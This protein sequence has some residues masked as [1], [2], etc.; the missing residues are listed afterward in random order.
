MALV[1]MM[2]RFDDEKV[3]EP[4]TSRVILEEK[5]PL[6]IMSAYINQQGGEILLDVEPENAERLA[7]AFRKYGVTVDVP[8]L[9]EKDEN[10]CMSCG[11]CVGLCPMKA[12]VY[13][14][15]HKVELIEAKC[16]GVTCG[17][18]VDACPVRAIRL[19]G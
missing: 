18:C 8:R 7:K 19:L 1:R 12:L 17:L 9:I 6:N 2:L 15:K 14:A 5:I 11:A 3:H 13:D 4:V 16:N 10:R